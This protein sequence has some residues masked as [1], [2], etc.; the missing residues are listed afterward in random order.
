MN[1]QR[2]EFLGDRVLNLVAAGYLYDFAPAER[3]SGY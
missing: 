2:Y 3:G 1:W